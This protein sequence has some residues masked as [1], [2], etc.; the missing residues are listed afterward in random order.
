MAGDETIIQRSSDWI[1]GSTASCHWLAPKPSATTR[2]LEMTSHIGTP[3]SW[4][5]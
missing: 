3:A 5:R 2:L 4:P 1:F